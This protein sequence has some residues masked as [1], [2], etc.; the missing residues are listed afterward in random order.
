MTDS[1]PAATEPPTPAGPAGA[2]APWLGAEMSELLRDFGAELHIDLRVRGDHVEITARPK[3][4]EV[5][6]TGRTPAEL[7]AALIAKGY[8]PW[9]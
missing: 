2:P 1:D 4:A 6:A 8:V 5:A 7:R 9:K 3:E